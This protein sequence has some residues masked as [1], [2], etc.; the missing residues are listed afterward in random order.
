M[1]VLV[2]GAG[3]QLGRAVVDEAVRRGWR[4]VRASH[5]ELPVEDRDAVAAGI[6]S[7]R[8][9]L[10]VHCAAFTDVD[11]CERDPARAE[12][13]NALGAAHVAQA[14]RA[15]G[16]WLVHVS[17]DYVFPGDVR[18][19][20]RVTDPVGPRSVYGRTKL[21]GE[22]AVLEVHGARAWVVRTSWVFGPGG[23]NF[24]RAILERARQR[25]PLSVVDDQI[26][27]PTLSRDLAAALLDLPA[28]EAP[29]GIW[30]AAN[31]G[32]ASWHAF[33]EEV[34]RV[35]GIEAP[36][37]KASSA[38]VL[39]DRPAPRPAWSV[40]D[41]SRLTELRGRPLPPFWDALRRWFDEEEGTR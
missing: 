3:G 16:A 23:R 4:A 25:L 19:S 38:E 24:P 41:C 12:A 6:A 39:R 37:A 18:R 33:A 21:A 40:L 35:A 17:T 34:L 27:S 30:H 22:Q 32:V 15:A 11:G 1:D 20:Y 29:P 8:P 13:V 5:A 28:L 7:E 2:T 36:I 9:Q 14:C 26:G 31:D 10:V